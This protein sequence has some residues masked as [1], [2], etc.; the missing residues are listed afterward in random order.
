MHITILYLHIKMKL[1]LKSIDAFQ[2][3]LMIF[4]LRHPFHPNATSARVSRE[5]YDSVSRSVGVEL[6]GTVYIEALLPTA[7]KH[8]ITHLYSFYAGRCEV[9]EVAYSMNDW[10][11]TQNVL[12]G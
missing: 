11:M 10:H 3:P 6:E 4:C 2:P 5:E 9:L 8:R 1:I 12:P 7:L